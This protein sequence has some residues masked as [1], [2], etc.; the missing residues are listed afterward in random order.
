MTKTLTTLNTSEQTLDY[1]TGSTLA[2]IFCRINNAP[3]NPY[4]VHLSF[5][6]SVRDAQV[7]PYQRAFFPNNYTAT[8]SNVGWGIHVEGI[9]RFDYDRNADMI[10]YNISDGDEMQFECTISGR[11]AWDEKVP[12]R[13]P[14]ASFAHLNSLLG[15]HWV[16]LLLDS[17]RSLVFLML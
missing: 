5:T 3:T 7:V 8:R 4:L 15:Q 17:S 2:I 6:P 16:S 13:G 14:E 10:K 9:G 1:E 12:S 11:T